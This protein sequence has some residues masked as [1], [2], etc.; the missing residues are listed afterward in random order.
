M[1]RIEFTT[2]ELVEVDNIVCP[3]AYKFKTNTLVLEFE[4]IPGYDVPKIDGILMFSSH[5]NEILLYKVRLS[6]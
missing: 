4:R 5:L 3:N 6:V 1:I 2:D